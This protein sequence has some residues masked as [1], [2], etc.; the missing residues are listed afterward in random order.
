[1]LLIVNL[2]E[3]KAWLKVDSDEEDSDIQLLIDSAELYLKNATGKIF[4]NS[5]VLAKLYCRVLISDWFENRGLMV[6]GKTTDKVR[7]TL[8]SIMMQLQYSS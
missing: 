8:Q 1:M 7:F 3:V 4:D 6:D 5:N 2:G